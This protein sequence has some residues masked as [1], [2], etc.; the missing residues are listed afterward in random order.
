[1]QEA[2]DTGTYHI[3]KPVK[4]EVEAKIADIEVED[5]WAEVVLSRK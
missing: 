4:G 3:S 5:V 2:Y 1:M